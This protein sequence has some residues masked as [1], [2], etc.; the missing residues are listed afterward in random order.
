MLVALWE[1]GPLLAPAIHERVG[2]PL[3]LA[4]T[5]T[6]K[7]LDRLH[8]KS[9]VRRQPSGKTFRYTAATERPTTER[10]RLRKLLDHALGSEPRPAIATLVDA[11]TSIDPALL[12]ELARVVAARQRSRRES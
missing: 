3:D 11:V 8:A 6:T 12:D 9:L 2:V 10:A 5:T 1:A 7:V 4:Y